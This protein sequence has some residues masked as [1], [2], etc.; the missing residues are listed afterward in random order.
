MKNNKNVDQKK[1]ITICIDD[2][3]APNEIVLH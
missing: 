2:G 1:T 3:Y